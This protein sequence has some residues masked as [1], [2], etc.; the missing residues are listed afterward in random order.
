MQRLFSAFPSGWPACGLFLLRMTC[1]IPL[2]FNSPANA[3]LWIAL[4]SW[5]LAALVLAGFWTPAAAGV[6]TLMQA[7]FVFFAGPASIHLLFA[8]VNLSVAMIGPGA[9]SID[10]R[11]YGR[12][13]I[14]IK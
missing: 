12:K 10:A 3:P 13:R 11:L 5:A 2:L 1:S 6:Q 7:G 4:L 8:A 9:W 14:D